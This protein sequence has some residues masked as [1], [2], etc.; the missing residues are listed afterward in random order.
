MSSDETLLNLH[1]DTR[2]NPLRPPRHPELAQRRDRGLRIEHVE[3]AALQL[4][5][6]RAP[7]RIPAA[8]RTGAPTVDAGGCGQLAEQA[9]QRLR[10]GGIAQPIEVRF[11]PGGAEVGAREA[12]ALAPQVAPEVA[13]DLG[14]AR[15]RAELAARVRG[16]P[17][18]LGEQPAKAA[19]AARAMGEKVL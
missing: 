19:A 12:A 5:E 11:Q 17:A 1:H 7:Q 3:S 13:Q 9:T 6:Q 15:G 14:E 4:V 10:T 2:A 18:D 8:G 16:G